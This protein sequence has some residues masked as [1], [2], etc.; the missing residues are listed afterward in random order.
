MQTLNFFLVLLCGLLAVI[1]AF[2][3][4][5]FDKQESLF[6]KCFIFTLAGVGAI[7]LMIGSSLITTAQ[8]Q[9]NADWSQKVYWTLGIGYAFSLPTIVYLLI[10]R[11][12]SKPPSPRTQLLN[13]V[14]DEV[15]ERLEYSLHNEKIIPLSKQPQADRT[16]LFEWVKH[17]VKKLLHNSEI[18]P[19]TPII[20]IFKH[21]KVKEKLLILGAPGAGKTTTLLELAREL[22]ILA[23]NNENERIPILLDI[24][25][26]S[27]KQ[28]IDKWINTELNNKYNIDSEICKRLLDEHRILP[29]LDGL[30]KLEQPQQNN[31]IQKINK[32][33]ENPHLLR[34]LVVCSRSE[35]Y[36]KC[37]LKLNLKELYLLPLDE[38]QIQDH[39]RDTN[40][41]KLWQRI[42]SDFILKQLAT[43]PF[44]LT[45]MVVTYEESMIPRTNHILSILRR[46]FYLECL[47]DDYIQYNLKDNDSNIQYSPRKAKWFLKVLAEQMQVENKTEFIIE[48]MQPTWLKKTS[49]KYQ[50]RLWVGLLTTLISWLIT[51]SC[52]LIGGQKSDI[53]G[54]LLAGIVIGVW[55]SLGKNIKP[56]ENLGFS[57]KKF[58]PSFKNILILG[59]NYLICV[60]L[61][62]GLM[63][64]I[65]TFINKQLTIDSVLVIFAMLG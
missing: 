13:A 17:S 59:L 9:Q 39:L 58:Y 11:E 8:A 60:L 4:N 47:F 34:N 29:L 22:I 54:Q 57:W 46:E 18:D 63:T 5:K 7:L 41:L 44:I 62:T 61:A 23:M 35:T 64:I 65:Y 55:G 24:S 3:P 42:K 48:K 52:M 6:G 43:S 21:S 53:S 38:Q 20:D 36:K 14:Q 15:K 28:P 37:S 33:L 25:T 30:D 40:R 12:N 16:T 27:Q 1:E 45:I 56:I 50:Y 10:T 26:W 19:D 32:S 2:L 49:Q 51:Y 31:F